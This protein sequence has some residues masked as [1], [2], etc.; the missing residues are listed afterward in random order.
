MADIKLPSSNGE[1]K[2][3]VIVALISVLVLGVAGY[4]VWKGVKTSKQQKKDVGDNKQ[5][6]EATQGQSEEKPKPSF[7]EAIFGNLKSGAIKPTQSN[8]SGFTFPIKKG[9]KGAN[10]KK[11][12]LLL[13]QYDKNILPKYGADKDFG[14][15]TENALIKIIGKGIVE[16]DDDI[17][18]IKAKG[19]QRGL[20]AFMNPLAPLGITINK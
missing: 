12:Q 1:N 4:F 3:G 17:N 2:G 15:E 8:I 14:T 13:L 6:G 20:T 19:I 5:E 16:S 11:L 9:Q 7:L 10:V 18:M